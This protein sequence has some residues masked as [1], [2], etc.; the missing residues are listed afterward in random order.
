[1]P[2]RAN[3]QWPGLASRAD[4]RRA[5]RHI[6]LQDIGVTK[7][8]LDRY[9]L[10]VRRMAPVLKAARTEADM[11]EGSHCG[12]DSTP[13]SSWTPSSFGWGCFEWSSPF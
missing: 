13:I 4:R 3:E 9:Y 5:R 2:P 6:V 12:M 1:M 8:T 7:A 10:A 11:D